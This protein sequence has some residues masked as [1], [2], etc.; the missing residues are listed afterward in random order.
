MTQPVAPRYANTGVVAE[1]VIREQIIEGLAELRNAPDQ[2]AELTTRFDALPQGTESEWSTQCRDLLLHM[3][4]PYSGELVQVSLGHPASDAV[5]PWVGIVHRGEAEDTSSATLGDIQTRELEVV[6]SV[7]DEPRYRLKKH[8]I[9]GID[10]N[11]QVEVGI[12]SVSAEA[13]IVLYEAVQYVIFRR[14]GQMTSAGI[15]EVT[16]RA[17]GFEPRNDALPRVMYV[18]VINLTCIVN[19]QARSTR[20]NVPWK[21]TATLRFAAG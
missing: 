6:G 7:D 11:V 13:S 1:F 10:L 18:P 3:L 4:D 8:T 12:W 5:L 9:T 21:L 19:R 14:K 17:D 2:L 16:M 15:R 20:D